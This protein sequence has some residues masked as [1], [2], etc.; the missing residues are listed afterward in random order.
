MDTEKLRLIVENHGKW[1]NRTGGERADLR[2]FANLLEAD[3]QRVVGNMQQLKS[4]EIE[5]YSVAYSSD[6]YR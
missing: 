1:L 2:V 6:I 3:L 4:M 5:T